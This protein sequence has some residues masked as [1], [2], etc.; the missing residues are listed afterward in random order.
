MAAPTVLAG[1]VAALRRTPDAPAPERS[2]VPTRSRRRWLWL[3]TAP[4]LG[5]LVAL[6][7]LIALL[8]GAETETA[9]PPAGPAP[10]GPFTGPGSLGGVAGTGFTRRQI[11]AVRSTSPYAGPRL[12]PGGYT[13]TSYGPPWGGIQGAGVATSGGVAL[14][15]GAPRLY[16]VAV[17][18]TQIAHGQLVHLWPN[19]FH[20]RGPFL[21][22]DTGGAIRGRRIDFYDWRGRITQLR[23]A[24]R[25]VQASPDPIV[26]GGP[27]VDSDLGATATSAAGCSGAL[28]VSGELGERI[29][30]IARSHL[31]K[32]NSIAGFQPPTFND[33]WC[34]WFATNTWRKAGVPIPVSTWSG[35]PYTWAQARGQLF[36]AVGQSPKGATPPAGAALMYGTTPTVGGDSQHVNLVDR[37]L[38]DGS[39]MVTGGNQD[40]SRVTRYGPCR[41]QRTDPARLTGPGCDPRP[42]YGIATP[43]A[44]REA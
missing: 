34:A 7:A 24:H 21:A 9:C 3:L 4:F 43:T 1:R 39:F 2:T 13:A 37:V 25:T 36:K 44:A 19:P 32:G 29:G 33:K 38:E 31:G 35:Y 41:L 12:S 15:G 20:W 14:N 8:A 28:P 6:V 18:P 22:A 40:G 17:D 11:T 5:F 23:W 27:D 42:I 16:M 30:Q 10:E 26:P